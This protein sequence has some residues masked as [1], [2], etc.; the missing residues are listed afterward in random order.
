M[1]DITN[2]L[3][4]QT[5]LNSV[6]AQTPVVQEE[7]LP[8]YAMSLLLQIPLFNFVGTQSFGQFR[9]RNA[10]GEVVDLSIIEPFVLL[11]ILNTTVSGPAE[12]IAQSRP[13]P[14]IREFFN[15]N[16]LASGLTTRFSYSAK[17]NAEKLTLSLGPL[18]VVLLHSL[19]GRN[20]AQQIADV[21]LPVN[22]QTVFPR[23]TRRYR[24]TERTSIWLD[25]V[26]TWLTSDGVVERLKASNLTDDQKT[27]AWALFEEL[28]RKT[29]PV[30]SFCSAQVE[31][32]SN[33]IAAGRRL[34][35]SFSREQPNA[36]YP[37]DFMI[38]ANLNQPEPTISRPNAAQQQPQAVSPNNDSAILA[39]MAKT[40]AQIAQALTLLAQ[41]GMHVVPAQQTVPAPPPMN[42]SA[43]FADIP[44]SE[45]EDIVSVDQFMPQE[46]EPVAENDVTSELFGEPK[47]KKRKEAIAA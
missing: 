34:A 13:D 26:L 27:V 43:A 42:T 20:D 10:E 33:Q 14:N 39:D 1:S 19:T 21:V 16:E 18:G 11:P 28:V 37:F 5:V 17:R 3:F 38:L 45:D 41:N 47:G 6:E 7:T 4:G 44:I 40:N 29:E 22:D 12:Y 31:Q 23:I 25:Q 9:T 2:E 15:P 46:P 36:P 8:H 24:A 35:F 30:R 32:I